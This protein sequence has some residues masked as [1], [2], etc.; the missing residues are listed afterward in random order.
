MSLKKKAKDQPPGQIKIKF[1]YPS[2][3]VVNNNQVIETQTSGDVQRRFRDHFNLGDELGRGGFSIVKKGTNKATGEVF[4]VKIIA[5]NQAEEEISLLKREIDIM[6]KLR[7]KN[8]IK[9]L[10]FLKT[11]K[12]FI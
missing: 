3:H 10:M 6:N 2:Q 12:I 4:A 1:F 7:H 5:K 9:L 11:L 8:I